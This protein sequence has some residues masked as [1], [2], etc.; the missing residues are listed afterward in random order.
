MKKILKVK[1]CNDFQTLKNRWNDFLNVS[2]DNNVFS[3]WEWLSIWWKHFGKEKQIIILLVED[4]NE[5][6]AIAPLICSKHK[7]LGFG[8]LKKISF[9]GSPESDYNTFILKEKKEKFSELIFD[10]LNRYVDWDYLELEDIPENSATMDLLYTVP[11]K[12]QYKN[13]EIGQGNVCRYVSLPNSMNAFLTGLSSNMRRNLKRYSRKLGEKCRLESKNYDEIGSVKEAMGTFFKLHQMRWKSKGGLDA[14]NKPILRDFHIDIAKCL[15]EKEC[16][17]LNFVT[18]NDEPIAATYGFEYN[19]KTYVYLT[20]WNP[21]YSHYMIGNLAH[22]Y[23]I[24]KSIQ[25][26]LKEYDLMR[27]NEAYKR[28]W[29]TKTRKNLEIRFVQKGLSSRIYKWL[30]KNS[31]IDFLFSKFGISMLQDS[32]L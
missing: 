18:A 31:K 5:I 3:T 4:E 10:Y 20:G 23:G 19:Q 1:E 15:A 2:L 11:L 27:G 32:K 9:A 13:W 29:T 12:I 28:L 14:F 30:T 22:M 6:M 7:F 26:G 21:T 17:N 24:Q 16:L 25:K 8:N